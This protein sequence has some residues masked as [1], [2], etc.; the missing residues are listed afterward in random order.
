MIKTC[1][2]GDQVDEALKALP[3]TLEEMYERILQLIEPRHRTRVIR[4]LQ[5]LV[6]SQRPV[7]LEE[8]VDAVATDPAKDPA[9]Q[10]GRRMPDPRSILEICPSLLR[11]RIS[12][13]LGANDSE[14]E[15]SIEIIELTHMT[16]K[17]YL[18]SLSLDS[19]FYP[20][21][22]SITSEMTLATVCISYLSA[23][24]E[25]GTQEDIHAALPLA[26]YAC[27]FWARHAYQ[28]DQLPEVSD[29]SLKFLSH[30]RTR[31][32]W[33]LLYNPDFPWE[34]RPEPYAMAPPLYYASLYGLTH[35]V[36]KM[37]DTGAEPSASGGRFHTALQAACLVG[38]EPVV[39]LLLDYGAEVNA[40]GGLYNDALQAA[41]VQGKRRVVELL[42]T[43]GANMNHNGG[44]YE[45]AIQAASTVGNHE[46]LRMIMAHW[47]DLDKVDLSK[48]LHAACS[49]GQDS[50]V[51]VLLEYGAD[52]NDT[53]YEHS[54]PLQAVAAGGYSLI[55]KLL[56][57]NGAEVNRSW[58]VYGTALQAA[59]ARGNIE[60]AKLLLDHN[61]DPSV[62]GG[63]FSN[64]LQ[65][66]AARGNQQL[67]A[68]LLER[69]CDP[70]TVGGYY[71]TAL[72]AASSHGHTETLALLLENGA[73]VNAQVDDDDGVPLLRQSL[74]IESD[75]TQRL[76]QVT[77]SEAWTKTHQEDEHLIRGLLKERQLLNRTVGPKDPLQLPSTLLE[78]RLAQKTLAGPGL[79]DR[80]HSNALQAASAH[81]HDRAVRLLL[82]AGA[83]PHAGG[84]FY[85]HALHAASAQGH[86]CVARQLLE[87]GADANAVGGFYGTALQAAAVH[88]FEETV[89]ALFDFGA[90]A[91]TRGGVFF[92]ALVAAS[93]RGHYQ[94]VA[95]IVQHMLST[96]A[97][98][99]DYRRAL[100]FAASMGSSRVLSLLL[101]HSRDVDLPYHWS[102]GP[103]IAAVINGRHEIVRMLLEVGGGPEDFADDDEEYLFT[104]RPMPLEIAFRVG[105]E[106]VVRLLLTKVEDWQVTWPYSRDA[107]FLEAVKW[108]HVSILRLFPPDKDSDG[109]RAKRYEDALSKFSQKGDCEVLELLLQTGVD[110]NCQNG[111]ALRQAAKRGHA[112][113]VQLLLNHG[114]E[115]YA[116]GAEPLVPGSQEVKDMLLKAG[117]HD[118]PND[119]IRSDALH[120][121]AGEDLEEAT[122]FLLRNGLDKIINGASNHTTTPLY[123][124]AR[125]DAL[126]T[127]KV[128]FA[129]G[130]DPNQQNQDGDSPLNIS[131]QRGHSSMFNLL[132][133]SGADPTNLPPDALGTAIGRNFDNRGLKC[134]LNSSQGMSLQNAVD[135]AAK[136][137]H[138]EA[139]GFFVTWADSQSVSLSYDEAFADACSFGNERIARFLL[140][141]GANPETK[142]SMFGIGSRRF[143][144]LVLASRYIRVLDLLSAEGIGLGEAK[145]ALSL[146][147]AHGSIKM[148]KAYVLHHDAEA[149][150]WSHALEMA[151]RQRRLRVVLMLVEE[152]SRHGISLD[153]N[154]T[155]LAAAAVGAETLLK[156]LLDQN[157]S[158]DTKPASCNALLEVAAASGRSNIVELLLNMGA[159][160]NAESTKGD[161]PLH[162]AVSNGRSH[163]VQKLVS[164]DADIHARDENGRTPLAIAMMKGR[165]YMIRLLLRLGAYR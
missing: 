54:T 9:F 70:N 76:M 1:I 56:V 34:S 108:G 53:S 119:C 79:K 125:R 97:Q 12:T 163:I 68:L 58:G 93:A 96:N 162:V 35:T 41:A 146:S 137:G 153:L 103:M 33:S 135:L 102:Y 42:L 99:A 147:I 160:V 159:D 150:A 57:D 14:D 63:L 84:G 32:I 38:F 112:D 113:A 81:G 149:D 5:M 2:D 83:D 89:Q 165:Q 95:I 145:K 106:G 87:S 77:G 52:C 120:V 45:N 109:E 18:I 105:H 66:A 50:C 161:R 124:A 142:G 94:T 132:V 55:V 80:F 115:I 22:D 92:T 43:K 118:D 65:A 21:A 143:S 104:F 133:D 47:P 29:M 100:V 23:V 25:N 148:I 114:A 121:A 110:V 3:T 17:E 7:T 136:G 156:Q 27:N 74:D 39:E 111:N 11:T 154:E 67:V 141:R 62:Q 48:A 24:D 126:S 15:Q 30:D 128:L 71:K 139:L 13:T 60:T 130:A 155:M 36:K 40:I 151:A 59:A 152:A 86:T 117:A 64:A 44:S 6:Y 116:Q 82:D 28:A 46:V 31:R 144:P 8:V 107:L 127:A 26:S 10:V 85:W 69:G 20:V 140:Q 134:I 78:R 49:H 75:Y 131:L 51:R 88:G 37:L 122:I 129:Y 90:I 19:A 157:S 158:T 138:E 72:Q 16:V 123:E 101:D 164:A 91:D 61:A 98:I 73:D 4:T